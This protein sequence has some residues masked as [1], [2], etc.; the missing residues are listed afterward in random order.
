MKLV[1]YI[2]S[3][4]YPTYLY[5]D[6]IV[7]SGMYGLCRAAQG[8]D[9]NRGSFATYAGKWIRGEIRQ[10]FSRRKTHSKD[11]S[12]EMDIGEDGTLGDIIQG[13]DD[14]A[15]IDD[16]TFYRQLTSE[17]REVLKL[18]SA[19]YA[20]YEIAQQLGFSEQK[21]NKLLRITKIKWR[22]YYEY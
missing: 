11:V 7:Q 5:D 18:H 12:L 22:N 17:E 1:Y 15:Y 16:E 10:E 9:E 6:D 3:K 4:E 2:I 19:G 8:W 20:T 13:D 14:V 21:V